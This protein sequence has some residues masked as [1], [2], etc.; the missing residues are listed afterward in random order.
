MTVLLR[1]PTFFCIG[2]KIQGNEYILKEI[3]AKGHLIG[4]HSYAH[5]FLYDLKSTSSF[6]NDLELA[7]DEIERVIGKKP[8]F[9]RP[10]Y[11]VTTPGIARACKKLNLEVIGWNIRSLDTQISDRQELLE[12]IKSK[13]SPGSILLLHDT[14]HGTELA[15]KELLGYLKENNYKIVPLDEAIEKKAYA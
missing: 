11:G 7:G 14:I 3:H 10:P 6:V 5:N 4:N 9:F 15:V 2:K 12:R 8:A 1:I 13:L